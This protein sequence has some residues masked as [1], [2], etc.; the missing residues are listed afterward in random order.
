MCKD[1]AK[2]DNDV[3]HIVHVLVRV[4]REMKNLEEVID[5]LCSKV[6]LF[7]FRIDGL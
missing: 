4:P 1:W 2:K 3:K 6:Y 7:L 5:D